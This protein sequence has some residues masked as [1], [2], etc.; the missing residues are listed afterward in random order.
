MIEWVFW[1]FLALIFYSYIGYTIL[2]LIL[3]RFSVIRKLT[4]ETE[5]PSVT[6]IIAAYNERDIIPAKIE[7]SALLDYPMEKLSQ[8]W[9]TDG[10]TDGSEQLLRQYENITVL[11]KS[12]REGKIGAINRAMQYAATPIVV[13]TDANSMLSSN[14]V[15]EIV[16]PFANPKVGCVTGEKSILKTE[17]GYAIT[18]GEGFYWKYESF[19]KK[20]ESQVN[21]TI[22]AVGELF[23]IRTSLYRQVEPDTILD[24]FVISMNI[25]IKGYQIKYVPNAV[26]YENSSANISEELKRKVRIAA[27]SIQTLTRLKG[28]LN[29]FS[30]KML[31]FQ[32]WS[33][34]VLRWTLVPFAMIFVFLG[35]FYLFFAKGGTVYSILFALQSA[36]YLFVLIGLL[37]R[38]IK[39]RL[40]II[41]A[42]YYMVVMNYAIILGI[43][44]QLTG[45]QSVNWEKAK[46]FNF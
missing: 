27:G 10:S 29:I 5:L 30:H 25:A 18:S 44:K 14:A 46:R 8:L 32:Y 15:R 37:F 21:S 23:A 43:I 33:H 22:G 2:L 20:L 41:F 13:F 38:N 1:I 12:E 35:G 34:K 39:S 3:S 24:D 36:F 28:L 19:I 40:H 17:T 9:V 7:N 11:H 4:S 31:S 16:S 42:P 26:A 6:L 45:N